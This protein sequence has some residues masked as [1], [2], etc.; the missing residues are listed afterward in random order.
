VKVT[1]EATDPDGDAVT[2]KYEPDQ[3]IFLSSPGPYITK[4]TAT[5]SKGASSEKF[6]TIYA[7]NIG[8]TP[9]RGIG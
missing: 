1:A 9:Q 3:E 4:V 7:I 5:D 2:L 6:D 8:I